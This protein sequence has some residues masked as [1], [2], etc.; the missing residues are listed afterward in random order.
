MSQNLKRAASPEEI[1]SG[2]QKR[3]AIFDISL[4]PPRNS[5]DSSINFP[6]PSCSTPCCS[7]P[8]NSSNTCTDNNRCTTPV[9]SNPENSMDTS[10]PNSPVHFFD[11]SHLHEDELLLYSLM[12]LVFPLSTFTKAFEPSKYEVITNIIHQITGIQYNTQGIRNYFYRVKN[13]KV[14]GIG[15]KQRYMSMGLLPEKYNLL[16]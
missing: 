10:T 2:K 8:L 3:Q 7:T 13:N 15:K 4:Q 6:I 16:P 5:M 14:K 1:L 12:T 9:S 11:N